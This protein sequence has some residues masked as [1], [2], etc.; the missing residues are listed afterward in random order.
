MANVEHSFLRSIFLS[1]SKGYSVA[2][3]NGELVKIKHFDIEDQSQVDDLYN[4]FLEDAISRGLPTEQKRL[5]SLEKQNFWTKF[6]EDKIFNMESFLNQLNK[7]LSKINVPSQKDAL[8][9][10]I[11]QENEKLIKIKNEKA[12]FIGHTAEIYANKKLN[13]CFI[14]H[15][16]RKY[17]N[18]QEKY[19]NDEQFDDLENSDINEMVKTFNESVGKINSN[20]IK[21]ITLQPFFQNYFYLTDSISDF[22]GK[23]VIDLTV[24]QSE[25]SYWG[26]HFKNIIQNSESKIPDEIIQNPDELIKFMNLTREAQKTFE[27]T[28]G[29]FGASSNPNMTLDDYQKMGIKVENPESIWVR[30][31]FQETGEKSLTGREQAELRS[32]GSIKQWD[33]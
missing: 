27:N 2:T 17:N 32:T 7:T 6:D 23:R 33:K 14:R 28:K 9:A 19:Y 4:G 24:F 15:S 21:K 22:W 12:N 1:I 25:V 11:Q 5:E 3:L 10:Q 8:E 18:L 30:K 20:V 16:I 31:K 26:K 29:E 13:D